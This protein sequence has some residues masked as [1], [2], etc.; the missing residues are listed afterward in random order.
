MMNS[1]LMN[2]K[3]DL[4]GDRA[5]YQEVLRIALPIMLQQFIA[6]SMG[7]TDSIMVG[8]LDGLSMAGVTVANKYF[9][10]VNAV[11]LGLTGGMGI[12]I[13]QNFGADDRRR[14]RGLFWANQLGAVSLAL[15][16]TLVISFFPRAVLSIF[17]S[18]TVTIGHGLDYLQ[19]IRFSYIPFAANMVFIYG[20]RSI[21]H[22]KLPMV[23]SSGA[24][25]L[26]TLL[27]YVLIFGKFGFPAMG[28]GGAGLAT[29]LAR[30]IEMAV[31]VIALAGNRQYFSMHI[32]DIRVLNKQL[33][34]QVAG[35]CLPLMGMELLWSIGMTILFWSYCQVSENVVPCLAIVETTANFNFIIYGGVGVAVSVM[36]GA[37]LGAGKFLEAQTNA[38]RILCMGFVA[39][40]VYG[41][42]V[43]ALS[44]LIP[45]LFQVA[46]EIRALSARMLLING[47]FY[48]VITLNIIAFYILRIGGDV[49]AF[50][51]MESG[52]VWLF[53]IPLAVLVSQLLKPDLI[54]FYLIISAAELV[55][56]LLGWHYIKAG[57]WIRNLT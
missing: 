5:F 49:R 39:S 30:L 31:Y 27:N 8:Q 25:V 2:I 43:M 3:G 1:R 34:K 15:I 47:A 29:L 55:K 19:Y 38:R 46:P 54:V 9:V 50:L 26:N 52:Y 56:G 22:T 35:K 32:K 36:V 16:F 33:L 53:L 24:V 14:S 45:L 51:V 41:V 23:V 57:R 44:S 42:A 6:M 17:V 18:D 28:T 21:G 20:F 48:A 13:S 4:I 12:F 10:I 7:F 11:I 40:A 37:R